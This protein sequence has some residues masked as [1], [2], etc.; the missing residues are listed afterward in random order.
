[1]ILLESRLLVKN[2]KRK[3]SSQELY[4]F[5][6]TK[7]LKDYLND[8]NIEIPEIHI[9]M[10]APVLSD[11]QALLDKPLG[12]FG[13]VIRHKITNKRFGLT[14]CHVVNSGL[15][16]R[17]TISANNPPIIKIKDVNR[18]TIV[19]EKL[20][21][22]IRSSRFDAAIIGPLTGNYENVREN[23]ESK[24]MD[25][26]G[27]S[28]DIVAA[29]FKNQTKVAFYG[30]QSGYQEG[31]IAGK[32]LTSTKVVYKDKIV[33]MKDVVAVGRKI[34]EN[35]WKA[36]SSKGDSG[37]MLFDLNSGQVLGML[38]A[39]NAK[40]SYVIPIHPFLS[41]KDYEIDS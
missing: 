1:M 28:R 14:C 9:G 29:D 16:T 22:N 40:F 23:Q 4:Q 41:S 10:G 36:I 32:S 18:N 30:M 5:N 24:R 12:T 6:N 21:W 33:E 25:I 3:F 34:G 38:V 20:F 7:D 17:R 37:S 31:R 8:A 15:S 27:K 39:G 13:C 35:K 2:L 19:E 11:R 26:L